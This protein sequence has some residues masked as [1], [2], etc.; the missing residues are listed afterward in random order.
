MGNRFLIFILTGFV[1]VP[2]CAWAQGRMSHDEELLFENVNRER[3]AKDLAPL[4]WDESLAKAARRHAERMSEERAVAHQ[5]SGEEDLEARTIAAG[6][7]YKSVSENIGVG[8]A[9]AELHDGWM[10]SPGHR[11]NILD[12]RANSIGIAVVAR[13]GEV[14]A[15]EDFSDAIPR[16]TLEQQEQKIASLLRKMGLHLVADPADARKS[17]SVRGYLGG[18]RPRFAANFVTPDLSRLPDNLEREIKSASY[19]AAA[20]GACSADELGR[21]RLAVLLY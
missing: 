2:F 7:R 8:V 16:L 5:Y 10:H 1:C 21:Y 6:A 15:V 18:G 19:S 13:N 20:V 11:A 4:Q 12:V 9:A 14:F 3:A 17:C